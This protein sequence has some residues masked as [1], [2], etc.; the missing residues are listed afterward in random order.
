MLMTKDKFW[1]A[2]EE[3]DEQTIERIYQALDEAM[4]EFE[5][6]TPKRMAMFLAQ[7]CHE[8]GHFRRVTENLNYSADG[9][10][11]I[12]PKYF[13]RAGR[14]STQFARQPEK[15][16]NIVYANRMGNGDTASGD[17]WRFR[18]RGFI[19]LTGRNNYTDCGES[20]EYDLVNDP[21]YLETPEGAA[22][23]AAWFWWNN[24]LNDFAD[25]ND[26]VGCTKRINGGTIG[27]A[28]RKELW[29]HALSVF[30]A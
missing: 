6:N 7:C 10:N 13:V 23:S 21:S 5:I 19:Q 26:I 9:L 4:E 2:F 8:S 18:G 25:K 1:E 3:C 12:F 17:G 11:K 14:D 16:A 30:E 28:E 24:D 22:R 15:I 20:L 27:L 29:E